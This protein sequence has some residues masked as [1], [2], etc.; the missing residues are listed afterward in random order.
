MAT[1]EKGA[2][3]PHVSVIMTVYNGQRHL[4]EAIESILSQTLHEFEF[5]IVDDASTD[6]TPGILE[7]YARRDTRIRILRND[8][9]IG[10]YPSA[11]RALEMACAPLIARMDADDISEPERLE[12]QASFLKTNPE[13]LLVGSG[14]R[15]IDENGRTRFV[16]MNP[17]TFELADWTARLRMPMVHPS[18][19]FRR[20]LPDGVPVRY[21]QNYEVA[22]DFALATTLGAA[23]KIASLGDPLVRYRMHASNISSTRLDLQRRTAHDIAS[24]AVR[25]HYP[26]EIAEKLTPL[27]NALY[28]VGGRGPDTLRRA[29]GGLDAAV[30]F[31]GGSQP[32]RWMKQQAAGTLALALLSGMP[33]H[34]A[35]LRCLQII[36][37][38]PHYFVPLVVRAAQH[39][40]VMPQPADPAIPPD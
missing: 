22:S 37:C 24:K 30:S 13:C 35:A 25:G 26:E 12:R 18:F 14:Y 9:N 11:N 8:E 29:V 15:A 1:H 20:N 31:D 32:P 3:D 28:H 40:K 17:M 21:D 39:W 4:A 27:L 34:R 19:C 38:A 36:A 5:L 23:G 16:K 2:G 33:S 6:E 7:G 10:P